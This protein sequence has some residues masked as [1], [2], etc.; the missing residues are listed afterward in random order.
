MRSFPDATVTTARRGGGRCRRIVD[1]RIREEPL[2]VGWRRRRRAPAHRLHLVANLP[3]IGARRHHR[4]AADLEHGLE[5]RAAIRIARHHPVFVQPR[6]RDRNRDLAGRHGD[7]VVARDQPADAV[8]AAVVG[9]PRAARHE[10]PPPAHHRTAHGRHLDADERLARFVDDRSRDGA[11]PP[12]PDRQVAAALAVGEH[13]R[14]RRPARPPH[15][16]RAVDVARLGGGQGCASP[17]AGCGMRIA[18]RSSSSPAA[19]RRA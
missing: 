14:Q 5:E 13:D 10:A 9:R 15:A 2:A 18:H 7:D 4:R 17:P 1:A 12:E 3:G 11:M 8:D 19:T 16:E 6:G